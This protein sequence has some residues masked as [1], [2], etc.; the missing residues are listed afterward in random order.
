MSN[1]VG[2]LRCAAARFPVA[3]LALTERRG[4]NLNCSDTVSAKLA[5]AFQLRSHRLIEDLFELVVVDDVSIK[6]FE[7]IE[8]DLQRQ[9]RL[10]ILLSNVHGA[11]KELCDLRGN[12]GFYRATNRT[13][14][15]DERRR[16][17]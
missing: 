9:I 8:H 4:T 3:P 2:T 12:V 16:I 1:F 11:L 17:A 7:Q 13:K 15:P 14:A 5:H 6:C 10:F